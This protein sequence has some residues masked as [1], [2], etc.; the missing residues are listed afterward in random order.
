MQSRR[1]VSLE[2][3]FCRPDF[4]NVEYGRHMPV[5]T[6]L[7]VDRLLIYR[8]PDGEAAGQSHLMRGRPIDSINLWNLFLARPSKG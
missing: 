4:G 5:F 7:E 2:R 1:M 6:A 3:Q 8:Q